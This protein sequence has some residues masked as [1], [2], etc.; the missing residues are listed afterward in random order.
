MKKIVLA[1]FAVFF[2]Q[3]IF[4]QVQSCAEAERNPAQATTSYRMDLDGSG[5]THTLFLCTANSR[6]Y[7]KMSPIGRQIAFTKEIDLASADGFA[8][9]TYYINLSEERKAD[10]AALRIFEVGNADDNAVGEMA[11]KAFPLMR[12]ASLSGV[13]SGYYVK[14]VIGDLAKDN[15]TPNKVIYKNYE[16]ERSVR[17]EFENNP[18]IENFALIGVYETVT[19]KTPSDIT[20]FDAK[21]NKTVRLV[22]AFGDESK[23]LQQIILWQSGKLK[24]MYSR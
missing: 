4:A 23:R 6:L 9:G 16:T 17:P 24:I 14:T 12:N 2:V 1:V 15:N 20:L 7:L 19:E 21:T 10:G 5:R 13:L 3:N 11:H 18:L 8:S 22:N